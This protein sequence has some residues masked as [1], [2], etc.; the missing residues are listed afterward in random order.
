[1]ATPNEYLESFKNC[2]DVIWY[3]GGEFGLDPHMNNLEEKDIGVEYKKGT[4]KQKS[5]ISSHMFLSG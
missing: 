4:Y 3:S 2:V 1:M 5:K